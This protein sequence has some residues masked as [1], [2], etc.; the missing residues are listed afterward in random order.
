VVAFFTLPPLS[1]CTKPFN[2]ATVICENAGLVQAK[3]S[4]ITRTASSIGRAPMVP[5]FSGQPFVS[6]MI[7]IH[8]LYGQNV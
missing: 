3:S 4:A 1:S 2:W 8:T 5:P 7:R 6:W